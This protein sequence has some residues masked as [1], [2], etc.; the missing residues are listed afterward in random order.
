[1]LFHI[2]NHYCQCI[3][4]LDCLPK[5]CSHSLLW[6][7]QLRFYPPLEQ[8]WCWVWITSR[9]LWICCCHRAKTTNFLLLT[10]W[11]HVSIWWSQNCWNHPRI[12]AWLRHNKIGSKILPP[13]PYNKIINHIYM[14]NQGKV[15]KIKKKNKKH[16]NKDKKFSKNGKQSN[17]SR[18]GS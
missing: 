12:P 11:Y 10:V 15:K 17:N 8:V 16:R 3:D 13:S 1:M 5:H 2:H 6:L 18:T 4:R 7:Y 14:Q 9:R